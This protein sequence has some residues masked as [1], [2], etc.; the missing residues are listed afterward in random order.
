MTCCENEKSLRL[1]VYTYLIKPYKV[2]ILTHRYPVRTKIKNMSGIGKPL[3]NFKKAQAQI[4]NVWS[5]FTN[6]IVYVGGTVIPKG[7][8]EQ[9]RPGFRWD[10]DV[11]VTLPDGRKACR[12]KLQ[13]NA[14]A[15]SASIR[16]FIRR[17]GKKGT[18]ADVTQVDIP[19]DST[20]EEAKE[21]I[22]NALD[23]VD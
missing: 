21:L 14:Q 7:Q 19:T 22:E 10:R 4:K 16:E 3:R 17:Q 15:K 6:P 2:Y 1:S 8:T 9:A 20:E 11:E 23:E 13:A 18:H 12:F 5:K